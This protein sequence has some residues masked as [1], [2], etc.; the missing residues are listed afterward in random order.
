MKKAFLAI[1]VLLTVSFSMQAQKKVEFGKNADFAFGN[2][3]FAVEPISYLGYGYHIKS[4][5]M[6]SAQD[7]FNSEFFINIMEL[8]IR[9][10]KSFMIALGVDYDL[11]QYRLDRNHIWGADASIQS[12]SSAGFNK[13]N[14]SRLNVHKFAIP[15][16]F[17]IKAGKSAIRLGAAGEYN[18]PAVVKTKGVTADGYTTKSKEKVLGDRYVKQFSYNVFGAISYGGLGVYARF[19]PSQLFVGDDAPK[20]QTF[21]VGLVLGLG[22]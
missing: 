4:Q 19:T 11:D 1:V 5:K 17:E 9:P 14:Y 7:A 10:S 2:K 13:K 6:D 16:S 15:L 3:V 22:M 8:G 21:T 18:L 20:V 12:L